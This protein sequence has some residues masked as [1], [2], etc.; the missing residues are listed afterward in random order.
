MIYRLAD[1]KDFQSL[2]DMRWEYKIKD[3]ETDLSELKE[4][5]IKEFIYFLKRG[6]ENNT[7]HYW[8]AE[9]SG[10]IVGNIYVHRIRKVPKPKKIFSE[11]GYVTNVYLKANYRN[12]SI[13]TRL[14]EKIKE[15]ATRE[16]IELL[17]LWPSEKS[18]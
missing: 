5:F 9:D 14:I 1:E 16:K 3:D 2:A 13:G 6:M 11:I 10:K 18:D 7:W 8:V 17:F 15:W 12:K 4:S